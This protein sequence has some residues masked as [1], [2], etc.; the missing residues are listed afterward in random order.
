MVTVG[1]IP[2]VKRVAGPQPYTSARCVP[3][4]KQRVLA[5]TAL[6]WRA[7]NPAGEQQLLNLEIMSLL[8]DVKPFSTSKKSQIQITLP[9]NSKVQQVQSWNFSK[10]TSSAK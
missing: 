8:A 6:Q 3:D 4:V 9:S 7:G 1:K 5:E 2:T 10:P